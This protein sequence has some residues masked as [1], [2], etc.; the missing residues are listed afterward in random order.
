MQGND[1]APRET[2]VN[3]LQVRTLYVD[4]IA[5]TLLEFSEFNINDGYIILSF[6]E[7]M[8]TDTVAPRN[9]TLHS[10]STGGESY[11]LT[12]YRNSTARNALKT[13]IQVYLTDSDVREIRLIST[14]ALGASSTY[15]SLL[16]GAFEDIAGNPVNATTTRFLVDTFPPDTTPPVLT[17]FTINMNEGTLTLTF[18]EV[19]SISSVDPLF[20]TFHN[21]ENETLVTSSYQLTGGDP[22]NENNDVITLTFSAIDFDKLK[23]LDS[24]ATSINDTFISITSDFVTD[25]SSVQVAAVDRQKASNYTPD[26]I[27]PFLVSYTLNLT[28]GSLVMEFSEYVNTSTFMPQQV[29]IL[30]E[31]VFISPTRVHRTLTGGTQVPSE[32]LRIIELMLNDNDLNF[33]KEDLTFATSINNTYI[34]LTASTVLD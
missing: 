15:I 13:S 9:I 3:A 21:N 4:S 23:S 27:N 26:S 19:V 34:T 6:S 2:D 17:S 29:T 5:P 22:S 8:D 10:S 18:D 25:L 14:L 31:P 20:I 1:V 28:S 32:D 11:T 30:N 24:L 16:S 7:P 12:G 33:I